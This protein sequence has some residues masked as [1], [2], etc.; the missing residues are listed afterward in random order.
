MH[1]SNLACEEASRTWLP[2]VTGLQA[3]R[4]GRVPARRG[5][6]CGRSHLRGSRRPRRGRRGCRQERWDGGGREGRTRM[7]LSCAQAIWDLQGRGRG[8]MIASSFLLCSSEA[9]GRWERYA[10][11]RGNVIRAGEAASVAR[12]ECKS[13]GARLVSETR[14][15]K[16]VSTFSG[17]RDCDRTGSQESQTLGSTLKCHTKMTSTHSLFFLPVGDTVMSRAGEPYGKL[18]IRNSS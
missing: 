5:P 13:E 12:R 6:W 18:Q 3:R 1:I 7:R 15:K 4:G 8:S 9:W 17:E 16:C 10:G 11:E 14:A 2:A